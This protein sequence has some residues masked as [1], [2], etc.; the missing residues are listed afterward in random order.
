MVKWQGINK[1]TSP[2]TEWGLCICCDTKQ[3]QS[4]GVYYIKTAFCLD[5]YCHSGLYTFCFNF[6]YLCDTS[7]FA[8]NTAL[9]AK[10]RGKIV[11]NINASAHPSQ[12]Q[13]KNAKDIEQC[14]LNFLCLWCGS[15]HVSKRDYRGIN[16]FKGNSCMFSDYDQN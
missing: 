6:T 15:L 14:I 1:S 13:V 16:C 5:C 4:L 12:E 10:E 9:S 8:M 11:I 2:A 7:L 3:Q